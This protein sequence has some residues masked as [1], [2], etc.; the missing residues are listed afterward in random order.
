MRRCKRLGEFFGGI[1][2][3]RQL[4]IVCDHDHLPT[5]S[6]EGLSSLQE[7]YRTEHGLEISDEQAYAILSGLMRFPY[8]T[9]IKP[10]EPEQVKQSR[11]QTPEERAQRK[12]ISISVASM[13]SQKTSA[14]RPS[15]QAE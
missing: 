1:A 11:P 7:F 4:L 12:A 8:L 10:L 2:W 5:P 13:E 14:P 9:E 3:W 15:D 6:P